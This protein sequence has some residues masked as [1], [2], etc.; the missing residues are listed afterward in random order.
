ESAG[1]GDRRHR[2]PAVRGRG[3]WHREPA[4]GRGSQRHPPAVRERF[5]PGR[6]AL[7][8]PAGHLPGPGGPGTGADADYLATAALTIPVARLI[9]EPYGSPRAEHSHTDGE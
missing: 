2:Y 5:A 4:D 7:P 8:V 3:G 6:G 9:V 1:R